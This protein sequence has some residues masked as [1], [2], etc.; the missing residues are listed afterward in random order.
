MSNDQEW[1]MWATHL[2]WLAGISFVLL[3]LFP[4]PAILYLGAVSIYYPIKWIANAFRRGSRF[5]PILIS[6]SLVSG[7]VSSGSTVAKYRTEADPPL[8]LLLE[9][10]VGGFAGAVA[11]FLLLFVVSFLFAAPFKYR[12]QSR[13]RRLR[14]QQEIERDSARREA[15]RHRMED[16]RMQT[17]TRRQLSSDQQRRV[18]ARSDAELLFWQHVAEVNSRFTKE[19]FDDYMRKYM[20]DE[21]PVAEV[22]ARG[23]QL[24]TIIAQHRETVCPT[25]KEMTIESLVDWYVAEKQRINALALDD[26]L[27]GEFLVEVDMRFSDLKQGLLNKMRP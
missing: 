16:Q 12:E 26:E 17:E 11:C 20:G 2:A 5:Y 3:Q 8:Q 13:Q 10:G 4:L 6:L 7:F 15:D 21:H 1:P 23:G 14:E 9:F 18:K 22:E 25:Q 19:M 27:K 24:R